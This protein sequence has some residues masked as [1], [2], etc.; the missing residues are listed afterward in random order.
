M[1]K[2]EELNKEEKENLKNLKSKYPNAD[3]IIGKGNKEFSDF[4]KK[5]L[6]KKGI[7]IEV[8][9][10]LNGKTCQPQRDDSPEKR[11]I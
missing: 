7:K 9:E 5:E 10:D 6:N 4:M 1:F 2:I 11:R 8:E 3:I